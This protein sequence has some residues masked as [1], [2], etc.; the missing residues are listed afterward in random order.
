MHY[1]YATETQAIELKRVA[2]A[3]ALTD[4]AIKPPFMGK[5]VV[6]CGSE[7]TRNVLAEVLGVSIL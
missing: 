1:L 4:V 2:S 7:E 6:W 5:V 3:R